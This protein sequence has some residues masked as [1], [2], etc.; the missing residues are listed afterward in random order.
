MSEFSSFLLEL[1]QIPLL[2][3]IFGLFLAG[4]IYIFMLRRFGRKLIRKLYPH[5]HKSLSVNYFGNAS[6]EKI[7]I[8]YQVPS[9]DP[10]ELQIVLK[11]NV[12]GNFH[13]IDRVLAGKFGGSF[14]SAKDQAHEPV[15]SIFKLVAVYGEIQITDWNALFNI[16]QALKTLGFHH[17]QVHRNKL[18][19]GNASLNREVLENHK[20]II[21]LQRSIDRGVE[22]GRKL[23][24][25]LDYN[26]S[27]EKRI[28]GA[29]T[30]VLMA[31]FVLVGVLG[32]WFASD[33]YPLLDESQIID[34]YLA[35]TGVLSLLIFLI[36]S[37]QK[38]SYSIGLRLFIGF[39]LAACMSLGGLGPAIYY[40]AQCGRTDTFVVEGTVI[41]LK[42]I[43]Q[44]SIKFIGL[45]WLLGDKYGNL[46]KA[47]FEVHRVEVKLAA[48]NVYQ[49]S[50]PEA[51]WL[52]LSPDD[53]VEISIGQG[54]LD[55]NWVVQL[56]SINLPV[57][58]IAQ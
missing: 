4:Q 42:K 35:A 2:W 41:N 25:F 52:S 5:A 53:K 36:L 40:N 13:F 43:D 38:K 33:W 32:I 10:E 17:I 7:I 46:L 23:Q 21:E 27:C 34:P 51:W 26:A 48:R 31:I 12:S 8:R 30:V 3:L 20:E 39:L 45:L 11:T 55:W 57:P 28:S 24:Q 6:L 47:Q 16:L 54:C 44:T 29:V 15:A 22:Y 1:A 50:I 9:N 49:F 56:H 19:I 14:L 37:I 58:S 18:I